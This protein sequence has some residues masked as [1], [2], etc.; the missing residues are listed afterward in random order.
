MKV[1]QFWLGGWETDCQN[2]AMDSSVWLLTIGIAQCVILAGK[3]C[4]P[5]DIFA[6]FLGPSNHCAPKMH[7][8]VMEA[9]VRQE[10]ANLE[11]KV[12]FPSPDCAMQ[13]W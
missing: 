2:C 5:K 6:Q 7:K 4:W 3:D 13:P 9:S 12:S 8:I 11:R 10:C 1:A